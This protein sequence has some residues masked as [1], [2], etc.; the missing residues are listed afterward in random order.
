MN[1]QR[2]NAPTAREAL[3]KA[4]HAFG[5]GTLILSNRPTA[6]GVEVVATAEDT[7]AALD[8]ADSFAN[9]SQDQSALRRDALP[10][11]PE[12]STAVEDDATQLAMSTLSFQD[13]V[14]ERMLRRRHESMTGT[15]AAAVI[16]EAAPVRPAKEL[17]VARPRPME[18]TEV[19][20][21]VKAVAAPKPAPVSA[22]AH[23]PAL[24]QGIVNELHAMKALIE[25]RFNTLTWLGQARQSP[26]QSNLMLKLIRA[27]YSPTL[28]RTILE[29]MPDEMGA[30]ESVRWVMDILERNLKTDAAAPAIHEEGGTYALVGAT[31][32][33]KTTTAA[34]LAGLCARTHGAASVGL[35]TLDTYR[36]GAH[37]QL[38]AF[39][40]MLGVVA[41]LAHDRAALQD[42]LSLLGNKKMV[43]IDTTG[44]APN[45]PR[46]RSMLDVL[47]LP[48]VNR[49]LVLNAGGHG[50][51]L[52]DVVSS[53]KS[54]GVQ[55]AVLS[56]TDEAAKLGPA[57][58]AIIRHQ[59]LL[60]GVTTG[61]KVP[62]DWEAADAAKL[63][64]QSMRAPAKSAFDPKPADLD[65][66]FTPASA[67]QAGRFDA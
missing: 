61:Q 13:Y 7:L 10:S 65:F 48:G 57:L 35:I 1:I 63:V 3:A 55:Q 39:G 24:S 12:A 44:L 27:G 15:A 8:T 53:F 50:D 28:A 66:F 58:D 21:P 45:D 29:R 18:R 51:T 32:V 64:R 30:T 62:E 14:R 16:P 42:L 54:T 26:I 37:E 11:A 4:R 23:A 20:A 25:D 67:A 36:V 33:G 41:H 56:K 43:L 46:K 59:L 38:R 49:L 47:D 22:A 52:D 6:N 19:Q 60:R 2:F 31:G 9:R 34:K 40:R 17:A 5:D